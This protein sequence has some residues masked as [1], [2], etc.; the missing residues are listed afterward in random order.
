[1]LV[2]RRI[3]R[4][5]TYGEKKYTLSR[6][7]CCDDLVTQSGIVNERILLA[8]TRNHRGPMPQVISQLFSHPH[9]ACCMFA[10]ILVTLAMGMFTLSRVLPGLRTRSLAL[11]SAITGLSHDSCVACEPIAPANETLRA[12]CTYRLIRVA[13]ATINSSSWWRKIPFFNIDVAA[14]LCTAAQQYNST[15]QQHGHTFYTQHILIGRVARVYR[16]GSTT[17]QFNFL[18]PNPQTANGI[19]KSSMKSNSLIWSFAPNLGGSLPLS[20]GEGGCLSSYFVAL[21]VRQCLMAQVAK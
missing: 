9:S 20:T 18:L 10:R 2:H 17:G 11:D 15:S 19:T 14:S 6:W 7:K 3:E 4:I 8:S 13:A 5:R 16:P 21:I 12:T 1:M